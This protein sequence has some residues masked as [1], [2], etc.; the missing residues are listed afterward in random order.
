MDSNEYLRF[1]WNTYLDIECEYAKIKRYIEFD[2][3]NY[4]VFSNEF[5]RQYMTI[6]SELDS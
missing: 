3:E 2:K 4:D 5:Y 6:C 1:S